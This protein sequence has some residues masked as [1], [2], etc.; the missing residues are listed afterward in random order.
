MELM[1]AI[2]ERKSYRGEFQDKKIPREDLKEIAEAGFLAPSGCNRQSPRIVVVDD[3]TLVQ[4]LAEI[5]GVAWAKNAPA[6][7][8]IFAKPQA[9]VN[10]VSYHVEDC[11]AAAENILLAVT[12]NGYATT[13]VEGQ[14]HKDDIPKRMAALLGAPEGTEPFI[15]MPLGIPVKETAPVKKMALEERVWFNRYEGE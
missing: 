1:Q 14:F 11:A 15:Y 12:A 10:G 2:R 8:L 13:W 7:I 4:E 9:S 3:A 5:S 6:T